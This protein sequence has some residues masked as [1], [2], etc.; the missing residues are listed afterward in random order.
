NHHYRA[1]P[2]Q[3]PFPKRRSSDLVDRHGHLEKPYHVLAGDAHQQRAVERADETVGDAREQ[4]RRRARHERSSSQVQR[5][6][7][8]SLGAIWET[9]AFLERPRRYRMGLSGPRPR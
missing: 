6:A 7:S 4:E 5:Q 2:T 3:L 9:E 8:V 1:P